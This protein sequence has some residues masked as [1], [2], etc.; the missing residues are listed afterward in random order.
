MRL[1]LALLLTTSVLAQS[2]ESI[3]VRVTE[4]E[5]SVLD[6][7]GHSLEGLGRDEFEIRFGKKTA[8]VSNFYEVRRGTVVDEAR[9]AG[10][11][12]RA[13]PETSIPTSLVI[14]IDELHLRQGSRKRAF[15][16]LQRYVKAN[17]GP[18]TT[19]T[20][21]RYHKHLDVRTRPT[22]KPGYVLAELKKLEGEP[23]LGHE[24]DRERQKL[25]EEI[26][27]I[28]YSTGM[29]GGNFAGESAEAIFFRVEMF[30]ERL[31]TLADQSLKALENAIEL[32]SAFEGRKVLLYVSEGLPQQPG[33]EL[34]D[35]WES[36]AR[37]A[38]NYNW[39][40]EGLKLGSARIMRFDRTAQFR[41]VAQAAQRA[42][43][44]IYS[45]DAAGVRGYEGRTM[46]FAPTQGTFNTLLMQSNLRGGLQFVADETG[47]RYIH[48][49]NNVDLALARMSEQFSSYYSLGVQPPRAARGDLEV[50]VKNR[51]DLRVYATRRIAP[52]TREEGIE[53]N[54]RA[55]LYTRAAANPLDVRLQVGRP[56]L[57]AGQCVA[58]VTLEATPP[59]LTPE[60]TPH[61]V[62][63]HFVMLNERN[64]ESELRRVFVPLQN[65]RIAHAMTLRIQPRPHVLSLAVANALS[66]ETSYLQ[67][68]VD[69]SACR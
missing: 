12:E 32:A 55:R 52:R 44:A 22:D 51:P 34:I 30:A 63:L 48:N 36:A 28:L 20:L 18:L 33:A 5:V 13:A 53:Q 7:N 2:R 9:A 10:R 27:D 3:D 39:K 50:K 1:V 45:F 42:G 4:I 6:R 35:Y 58:S 41:R 66:G 25:I 24:D 64:D 40:T 61:A 69:G 15:D 14:V 26:D 47:G 54:V 21:I 65:G 29:G 62:E 16:A 67:G 59:K 37:N 56:S 19:V 38:P 17:V 46:E 57:V 49:E 68:D 23:F 31:T 11:V 8:P 60:L 43:V